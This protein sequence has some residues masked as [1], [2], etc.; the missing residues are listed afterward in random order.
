MEKYL[1]RDFV[2]LEYFP[3]KFVYFQEKNYKIISVKRGKFAKPSSYSDSWK[4]RE[5][6]GRIKYYTKKIPLPLQGK[7]LWLTI[8]D[9]VKLLL[10]Y[11]RSVNQRITKITLEDLIDLKD[12]IYM[13]DGIYVE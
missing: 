11:S 3:K 5:I 9:P 4:K 13:L 10:S 2:I 1:T 8:E 6:T 7:V 12:R